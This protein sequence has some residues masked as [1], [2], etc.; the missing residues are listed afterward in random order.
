[1][2]RFNR[3]IIP[4][5][6]LWIYINRIEKKKGI[7]KNLALKMIQNNLKY[8]LVGILILGFV[9]N[10]LS[11]VIENDA[12][13]ERQLTDNMELINSDYPVDLYDI[14]GLISLLAEEAVQEQVEDMDKRSRHLF[15]GKRDNQKKNTRYFIGKRRHLFIG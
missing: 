5:H 13:N 8:L 2:N 4:Y 6:S 15:I 3:F 1:M 12:A 10:S 9:Q 7:S 11:N 14:N